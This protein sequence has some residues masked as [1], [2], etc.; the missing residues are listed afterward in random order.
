MLPLPDQATLLLPFREGALSNAPPLRVGVVLDGGRLSWWVDA[1]VTFLGGIPGIE[2]L[3]LDFAERQQVEPSRPGWLM[4]RLYSASRA[5]FDPFGEAA[6]GGTD[7]GKVESAEEIRAAGC[8]VLIWLAGAPDSG[9]EPGSQA[10][11][12][13]LTVRLG[14]RDQLV[15]F[16]QE[17]SNDCVTSTVTILWHESSLLNGRPVRAAE[18]S[19]ERGLYFTRNAEE[20]LMAAI[21]M[22]ATLCLEIRQGGPPYRETLRGFPSESLNALPIAG[23]PSTF[24]AGRFLC[25][26]LARSADLRRK[27]QGKH[28]RWFV[29]ARPNSGAGIW[30]P[31]TLDLTGFKQVPLPAGSTRMADPFLSECAGR[32]YLLFEEVPE[33]SRRGRLACVEMLEDGSYSDMKILLECGYHVS[34]PCVVPA[35]GEFFLVPESADAGRVDLYR[36]TRFPWEVELVSSLVEGL[37][38]VDTTPFFLNDRWYFFTTTVQPFMETLL[39]WADRL[40]G[41]WHLH[42]SSP[43]SRSV[44]NTRSAGNLVWRDGRLYRPTQDCSVRYGY[45]IQVNEVVR[46]TP[47]EFE[48]RPVS[49][50]PPSWM[51]GLVGTHTWNESPSFQVIDGLRYQ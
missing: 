23:Y 45:A 12:G 44:R 51:P 1:L 7:A 27:R 24:A 47:A 26:K 20:P 48:E 14:E 19:T 30:D 43:V 13:A 37:A 41:A 28:L 31:T 49:H 29:A 4:E 11:Y 33:E 40:D 35:G 2:V 16:W 17:V 18:T 15:P 21:R 42:P 39:F 34:Y 6:G 10:E 38:L 50:V 32:N 3:L 36:F 46:L 9:V 8:G 22:L 5:R 25:R